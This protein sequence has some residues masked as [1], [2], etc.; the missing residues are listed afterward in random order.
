[1]K[2][3]ISVFLVVNVICITILSCNFS[4]N[5]TDADVDGHIESVD[6]NDQDT[7][8]WNSC[9]SCSDADKDTYFTG[10]DRYVVHKGPDCNDGDSAVYPAAAEVYG[11][12][13][14][15]DCDG[16]DSNKF[17]IDPHLQLG[18]Q[19][20]SPNLE[21]QVTVV[22]ETS[23]A[24]TASVLYGQ[25]FPPQNTINIAVSY[26]RSYRSKTGQY[27]FNVKKSDPFIF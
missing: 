3:F 18:N 25:T 6:C 24:K 22:W 26:Y 14:D 9:L 4:E 27:I 17:L 8:N 2:L 21:K 15:Q 13:I 10:C 1:L 12:S 11:D 7:D 20:A 16:R 23:S 19:G 5:D